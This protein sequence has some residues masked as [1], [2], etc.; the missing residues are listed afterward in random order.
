MRDYPKTAR[1]SWDNKID[2]KNTFYRP[3]SLAL[4]SLSDLFHIDCVSSLDRINELRMGE[5]ITESEAQELKEYLTNVLKTRLS[6]Q[7]RRGGQYEGADPEELPEMEI[8]VAGK[9][10]SERIFRRLENEHH[11]K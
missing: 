9:E 3:L 5:I 4:E 10:K 11:L 2:I 8:L 6:L 1:R 7:L